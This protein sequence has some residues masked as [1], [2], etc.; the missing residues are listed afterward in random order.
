MRD[1]VSP[2]G[3]LL[4]VDGPIASP[5]TRTI[6]TPSIVTDLVAL[7]A[8]NV[9]IAFITGR[10]AAFIR[11]EVVAPLV[12]AGLPSEFRMYGVCEKGAVWFPISAAGMGEVMVDETVALPDAV[13]DELRQ[14]VADAYSDTMFFDETKQAMVSVEH[15]T[16]VDQATFQKA[17]QAF[18]EAAFTTLVEHGLGVRFGDRDVPDS[19]GEIPFRIDPT[20]ISTDIESVRLDKNHAAERALA[21]FAETG[22]LPQLWRSV[23]DSRSD[24]LMSDHLHAAG[25]DVTHVD[26]RPADGILDRP[27]PVI[28][29]GEQIHDEAGASFLDYWVD[30]LGLRGS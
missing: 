27:Y 4:D 13:V 11:E 3:L 30:K 26:V 1:T 6:T 15:R 8:A 23:G 5:V 14:L 2:L 16:D 7:A 21:F 12:A 24:Y 29:I 19:N 28:V 25:Y 20:I 17:Q 9:P 10:S 22:P 18:N